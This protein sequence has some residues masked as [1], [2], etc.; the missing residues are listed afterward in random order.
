MEQSRGNLRRGEMDQG[1]LFCFKKKR[2]KP[3]STSRHLGVL[4]NHAVIVE[5][6]IVRGDTRHDGFSLLGVEFIAL[7]EHQPQIC[8]GLIEEMAA[9]INQLNSQLLQLKSPDL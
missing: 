9:K 2:G 8:L 7:I 5:G 1:R 6:T 4:I 3:L